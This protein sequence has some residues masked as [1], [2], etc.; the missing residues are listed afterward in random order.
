MSILFCV[1]NL[2]GQTTT[3]NISSIPTNLTIINQTNQT[4]ALMIAAIG[5]LGA[6]FG[7]LASGLATYYI[8]RLKIK[9]MDIQ[10]MQQAY[11]QLYSRRY[12]YLQ[13]YASYFMNFISL[14]YSYSLRDYGDRFPEKI[15][16]KGTEYN[17]KNTEIDPQKIE[18]FVKRADELSMILAQSKKEVW[19][20]IGQIKLLFVDTDDSIN[21]IKEFA[22]KFGA[23]EEEMIREQEQ[24]LI[25]FKFEVLPRGKLIITSDW[26]KAK[27]ITLKDVYINKFDEIFN[28]LLVH[29]QNELDKEKENAKKPRYWQLILE[30][31]NHLFNQHS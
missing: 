31:L 4:T 2:A 8:E 3:N 18:Y 29:M 9:N 19:E 16:I 12:L 25:E 28:V 11:Y 23:F 24:G 5:V 20:V 15:I 17:T 27:K 6:V 14:E 22:E 7:V 10:R 21:N 30:K 1:N 26:P 13:N